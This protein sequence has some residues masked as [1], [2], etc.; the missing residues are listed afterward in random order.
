MSRHI[1]IELKRDPEEVIAEILSRY[2]VLDLREQ[3][4]EQLY[5]GDAKLAKALA[6]IKIIEQGETNLIRWWK[7]ESGGKEYE[8]RR[9]ENFVFCSCL[10]F[11]FSKTVCKHCAV[12][13]QAYCRDCGVYPAPEHGEVCD[14][15][16]KGN[17]LHVGDR[18]KIDCKSEKKRT[19]YEVRRLGPDYVSCVDLS[20]SE[21][22]IAGSELWL[23]NHQ[24]D[25]Y[26]DAK[27]LKFIS[28]H[29]AIALNK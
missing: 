23:K 9:F 27:K 25:F 28:P 13:T 29:A 7:I 5:L 10:D 24:L 15:C 1:D 8:V 2:S 20:E 6:P 22:R 21:S 14:R 11:M 16:T 3:T 26:R 19:V 4:D 18:F 17:L 12:T